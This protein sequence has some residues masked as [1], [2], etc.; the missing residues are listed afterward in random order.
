M[1]GRLKAGLACTQHPLLNLRLGAGAQGSAADP[2]KWPPAS[3]CY[4]LFPAGRL[5]SSPPAHR[6]R[7]NRRAAHC[8]AGWQ[9]SQ[10]AGESPIARR[11]SLVDKEPWQKIGRL[12]QL[13]SA[14]NLVGA[15]FYLLFGPICG[16]Y[17]STGLSVA[18]ILIW[19]QRQGRAGEPSNSAAHFRPMFTTKVAAYGA[20]RRDDCSARLRD[21][22]TE[23][24]EV[25]PKWWTCGATL[26][27]QTDEQFGRRVVHCLALSNLSLLLPTFGGHFCIG[28]AHFA[29][30]CWSPQTSAGRRRALCSGVQ[31]AMQ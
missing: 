18:P 13:S 2:P 17:L 20:A 28:G 25:S 31:S 8:H 11:S 23:G 29:M 26:G 1:C 7:I 24:R 12:A 6:R 27:E 14:A 15:D 3:I 21:G 4:Q 9:A 5:A 19:P 30:R 16:R 22:Q 10:P